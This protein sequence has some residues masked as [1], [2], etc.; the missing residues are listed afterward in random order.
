[1]TVDSK[2][3]N[4]E[5]PDREEAM[6]DAVFDMAIG[7]NCEPL[8][9]VLRTTLKPFIEYRESIHENLPPAY[10]VTRKEQPPHITVADLDLIVALDDAILKQMGS[11]N[12]K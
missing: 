5:A 1:M 9:R 3:K 2:Y 10:R 12:E 7:F 8:I 4:P 6:R 11:L